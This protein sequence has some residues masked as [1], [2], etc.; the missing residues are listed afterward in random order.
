MAVTKSVFGKSPEGREI[1]LYTL[2]NSKG[3]QAKVTD[4]GA[5]L[6][7]ILVPD[8][9]GVT[10]DVTLGFDSVDRYYKNYSFFGAVIGPCANR[11]AGAA[12]TLDG[13]DYRMDQNDGPNNLHTHIELGFHKRI[14]DAVPGENS[15]TFS[16]EDED[17]YLGFPGH[18]KV[19]VTYSLDE[20]NA[21][22]LH[23]H[24]SSDKRTIFNLTNHSYFNLDGQGT[25]RIEDHELWLGLPI[26]HLWYRDP[27]LPVRSAQWRP[28]PWISHSRRRSEE[29]LKQTLNS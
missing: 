4:L 3:M 9:Q 19:S 11:T 24:A 28:H 1:S 15:V 14:W 29:I 7:G 2:S 12:Y 10:A 21:L 20:E 26:S 23:Y 25:G 16:L 6:V 13:V 17:G 8:A 22:R 18:K 5:N 27:F